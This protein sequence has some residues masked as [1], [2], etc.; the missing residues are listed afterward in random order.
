VAG[1]QLL[2]GYQVLDR[3]AERGMYGSLSHYG[4]QLTPDL[5]IIILYPMLQRFFIAGM[6][7]GSVKG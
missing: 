6:T 7:V 2:A 1:I 5:P 3:H 4:K